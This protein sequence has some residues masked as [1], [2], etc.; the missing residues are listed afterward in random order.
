MIRTRLAAPVERLVAHP[1]PALVAGVDA[2]RPAVHVW[3]LDLRLVGPVGTDAPVYG[4][5][6]IWERYRRVP[7]LAWHPHEP[8][9]LVVAG[10]RIVALDPI[11]R[12]VTARRVHQSGV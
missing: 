12:V 11:R 1:R 4:D 10:R 6:P 9:L 2:T 7:E 5:L 3:D 8:V